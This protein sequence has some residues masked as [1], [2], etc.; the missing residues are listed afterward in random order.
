MVSGYVP[1][2]NDKSLKLNI[3]FFLSFFCNY[4]LVSISLFLFVHYVVLLGQ[5]AEKFQPKPRFHS[6]VVEEQ[7]HGVNEEASK[8][9]ESADDIGYISTDSS[10]P[11]IVNGEPRNEA[12][13]MME[14][15]EMCGRRRELHKRK[16]DVLKSGN[17]AMKNQINVAKNHNRR[18]SSSILLLDRREHVTA[19]SY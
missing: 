19:T 10:G 18:R 4:V 6:N 5:H 2:E 11:S 1:Y 16:V 15:K 13:N 9:H 12:Y 8:P 17:K 3:L 7:N 14:E